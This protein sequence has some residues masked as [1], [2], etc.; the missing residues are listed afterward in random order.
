[1]AITTKL[2]DSGSEG[3]F[4]FMSVDLNCC[5]S[6]KCSIYINDKGNTSYVGTIE[7]HCGRITLDNNY[8]KSF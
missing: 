8:I 5:G 6:T 3:P 2:D 4:L 1:M 7:Y